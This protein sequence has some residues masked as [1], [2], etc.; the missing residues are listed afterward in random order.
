MNASVSSVRMKKN[1]GRCEADS[2]RS[3]VREATGEAA[4]VTRF[5][6]VPHSTIDLGS[7]L[8]W[9]LR[10]SGD[11]FG[12]AHSRCVRAKVGL[13]EHIGPITLL[14]VL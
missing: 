3:D 12:E 6:S 7:L 1:G 11:T 13:T 14:A 5:P 2:G 9:F 8:I 10:L 4:S